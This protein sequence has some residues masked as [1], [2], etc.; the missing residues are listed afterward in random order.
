ML[1][2]VVGISACASTVIMSF[3]I[4]I[5]KVCQEG[6]TIIALVEERDIVSLESLT[7][8]FVFAPLSVSRAYSLRDAGLAPFWER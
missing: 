8:K 2:E 3:S 1:G 5:T 6:E 4:A 7:A